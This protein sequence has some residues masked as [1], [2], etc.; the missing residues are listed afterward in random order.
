MLLALRVQRERERE[1]CLAS[2]WPS[3]SDTFHCGC[4]GVGSGPLIAF[5]Y[6][7]VRRLGTEP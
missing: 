6:S 3:S 2:I 4:G 1:C 5:T 7:S